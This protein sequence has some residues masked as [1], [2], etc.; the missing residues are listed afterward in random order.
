LLSGQ[1]RS[2]DL[3]PLGIT[4][5]CNKRIRATGPSANCHGILIILNHVTWTSYEG[6]WQINPLSGGNSAIVTYNDGVLK[7]LI[8]ICTKLFLIQVQIPQAVLFNNYISIHN[9]LL[10]QSVTLKQ[11]NAIGV[12]ML[13]SIIIKFGH[14][15]IAMFFMMLKFFC[16]VFIQIHISILQNN[17]IERNIQMPSILIAR[18]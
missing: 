9:V 11:R 8:E 3:K 16:M 7:A 4:S 12:S 15:H 6:K 14:Y 13:K 1:Q 17:T 2:F 5:E 10:P 18:K